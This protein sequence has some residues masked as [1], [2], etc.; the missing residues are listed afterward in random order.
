MILERW[1]EYPQNLLNK[2][3]TTYPGSMDD[4]PKLP[5]VPKLDDSPSF[6]EE[7]KV[8][9]SLKNYKTAGPDNIPIEY[10]VCAL[11]RR[12]HNFMLDCW[13][14]KCLQ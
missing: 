14:A 10:G 3:H 9:L 5:I 6:D 2:V 1:A 11:H 7:E 4:L 13:S 12:L 8:I